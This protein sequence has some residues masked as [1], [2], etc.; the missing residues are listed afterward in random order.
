MREYSQADH[1]IFNFAP[2]PFGGYESGALERAAPA[3]SV[4]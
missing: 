4:T 3:L 2:T 1:L